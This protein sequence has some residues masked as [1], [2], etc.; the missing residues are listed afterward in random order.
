MKRLFSET[1][2][3]VP[4]GFKF[5]FQETELE[6]EEVLPSRVSLDS[7]FSQEALQ[8][9][10][11]L[12]EGFPAVV[13]VSEHSGWGSKF[14]V[15]PGQVFQVDYARSSS[16]EI[17]LSH[18]VGSIPLDSVKRRRCAEK[19]DGGGDA[20]ENGLK[21]QALGISAPKGVLRPLDTPSQALWHKAE[22]PDWIFPAPGPMIGLFDSVWGEAAVGIP[23]AIE[24]GLASFAWPLTPEK[25]R[26]E[27]V[28]I[29]NSLS[30][31]PTP[32]DGLLILSP[33]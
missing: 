20:K 3:A 5:E 8:T 25:F 9:A 23:L 22:H 29:S 27:W 21:R 26:A 32:P 14:Q 6:S 12:S 24:P 11:K 1:S 13:A 10:E 30:S 18:L 17:F 28:D 7:L 16:L 4:G 2:A 15:R 19:D 33:T 31:V